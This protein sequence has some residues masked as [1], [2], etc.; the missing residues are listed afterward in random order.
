MLIIFGFTIRFRT[1]G[2]TT[3]FCPVCG[4]DRQGDQR[5][6]RRWFTIFWIPVIP[7][8]EVGELVECTTCH[9]RFDPD[10]SHRPTTAAL[11]EVLSTAVRVLAA[12]VVRSGDPSNAAMRAAAVSH[13]RSTDPTYDD[14]TLAGDVA[15]VDPALADQYVAPLAET[16]AITGKEGL[17]ADLVRVALAGDTLT[18]DQRRVIDLVGQ[19]L[20]LTPAHVTGVVT[21]VASASSPAPEPPAPEPPA[22]DTRPRS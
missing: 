21:S 10:V 6:A 14:A 12:M 13:V 4:G 19:G 18:A 15:G 8:K 9:T 3:F 22:D 1:T 2:T 20:G 7:L 5:V 17:V 16:L 11:G